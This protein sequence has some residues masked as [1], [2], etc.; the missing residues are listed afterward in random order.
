MFAALIAIGP[1]TSAFA[2]VSAHAATASQAA[3]RNDKLAFVSCTRV[4]WCLATGTFVTSSGR[5]RAFAE[6]WKGGT[7]HRVPNPPGRAPAA[8]S[9]ATRTFCLANGGPTRAEIWNGKS[10]RAIKGPGVPM[11]SLSCGSSTTCMFIAS[12]RDGT[13]VVESWNGT[14]W[15]LWDQATNLCAGFPPGDCGLSQVSCGSATNCVAVGTETL[16]Q[17]PLVVSASKF[18][19]GKAWSSPSP[20]SKGNPAQANAVGCE[21]GF[22]MA[23]GGAYSEIANGSVAMAATWDATTTTWKDVSPDLGTVC[24]QTLSDC[25]WTSLMTCGSPA[26][27]L[28]FYKSYLAWNGSTWKPTTPASAGTGTVLSNVSCGG[29]SCM[30]VGKVAV[31]GGQRAIAEIWNG[32]S[33][34]VLNPPRPT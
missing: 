29:I 6:Q 20:P 17:E 5:H 4:F 13:P 26:N 32:T 23:A 16:D 33:W 24:A 14:R 11:R 28:A 7:W 9:C 18:W 15:H 34:R 21:A 19:N 25:S 30:A 22:C 1:A 3:P 2:A 31:S 27:C 8:L 12:A 10:W